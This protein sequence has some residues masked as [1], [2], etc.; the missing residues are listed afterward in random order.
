[1][2]E[3]NIMHYFVNFYLLFKKIMSPTEHVCVMPSIIHHI[4]VITMDI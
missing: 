3:L 1:M 2:F 4:I